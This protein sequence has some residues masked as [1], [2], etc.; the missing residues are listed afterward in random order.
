MWYHGTQDLAAPVSVHVTLVYAW[1]FC[2]LITEAVV[3]DV[4]SRAQW[5]VL[6]AF[7]GT[8][9]ALPVCNIVPAA[10]YVVV[11]KR[12]CAKQAM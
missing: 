5:L 6:Q 9:R 10:L 2:G 8:E 11:W 4:V 3:V 12:Y 7:V 1:L